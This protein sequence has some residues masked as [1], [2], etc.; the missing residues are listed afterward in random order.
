MTEISSSARIVCALIFEAA[1][2]NAVIVKVDSTKPLLALSPPQ[3]LDRRQDF[4]E[5]RHLLEEVV[6]PQFQT[7]LTISIIC[8]CREND[9]DA[10]RMLLLDCLE[11][12]ESVQPRHSQV[13]N[14]E[15][16]RMFAGCFNCLQSIQR[17]ANNLDF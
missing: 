1:D 13:Q 15:I 17:L 5:L 12:L 14:D 11:R 10:I 8:H 6:C 16:R 4:V 7:F 9:Y 2:G 3:R